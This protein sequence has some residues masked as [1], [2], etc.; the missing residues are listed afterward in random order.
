[1]DHVEGGGSRV[2]VAYGLT[3]LSAEGEAALDDFA[4]GYEDYIEEWEHLV[5]SATEE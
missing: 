2:T 4:S 3:A 1:M 5:A